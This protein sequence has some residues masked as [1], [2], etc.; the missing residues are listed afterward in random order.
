MRKAS[1]HILFVATE[2]AAGMRPYANA[3][4]HTMWQAGDH[5]LVVAKDDSV[6]HDFDDLPR[7]CV[8][9]IDYPTSKV[10]KLAFRSKP[11]LLLHHIERLVTEHELQ[12]IYCL[13][14]ELILSNSIK[15]VQRV[16][17][18]LYTIHDAVGHDSKYDNMGTWLKHKILIHGPQQRLIRRTKY[19]VTNSQEQLKLV[20]ER[21]P[22]HQVYYA[23]FPTLVTEDIIHGH[24]TV[25]ELSGIGSDYI[26]FFGNLQLYKGVHL[27]YDAFL[28]HP[29]L[30][31]LPLVIAG[32]GYIYF[33]RCGDEQGQ[34]TFINRYIGDNE[35][36]DLFNHAA[37]VVYPYISATQSGVT[38]IASYF[39]KPMVLSDLPFFK[40]TCKDCPGITFFT[41]GDSDSLA[42]AISH[43]L[44]SPAGTRD[45]YCSQY[46]P[47]ALRAALQDIIAKIC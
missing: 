29:E 45:L 27:L 35:I 17:P 11:S 36:K 39:D 22:Y 30:Q 33:P 14:G 7:G 24:A 43:S 23:P 26:L 44:Q 37:V 19:Q 18:L 21:Y 2:Y 32:S 42:A 1:Q 5:V 40:Q 20:K 25:P 3:I 31:A 15:R 46:K 41:S 16:A 6:K 13:T 4:I 28:S 9:W 12:L 47:Q 10:R 38:S 8:T 34:I